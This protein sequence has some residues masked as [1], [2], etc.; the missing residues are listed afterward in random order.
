VLAVPGRDPRLRRV[1]GRAMSVKPGQQVVL[2]TLQ[3]ALQQRCPA[4][5]LIHHTDQGALYTSVAYRQPVDRAGLIASMSRK[6]S[7]YDNAFV[8]SF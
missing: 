2:R 1:I 4:P 3:M 8:D 7:C 5:G 6:A